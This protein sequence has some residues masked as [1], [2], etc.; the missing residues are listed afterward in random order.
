MNQ[1]KA[2]SN[3]LWVLIILLSALLGIGT[4]GFMVLKDYFVI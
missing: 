1:K 3:T 2:G 4:F